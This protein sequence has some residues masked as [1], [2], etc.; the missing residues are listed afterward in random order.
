MKKVHCVVVL[1]VLLT[2]STVGLALAAE[3]APQRV[4]DLA[5]SKLVQL[6]KNPVIIAAVRAENAKGK[7]LAEIK[8]R[9]KKWAATPGV[10]S[11]M[12]SL[13]ENDCAKALFDI[14]KEYPYLVEIFVKD[15]QGAHVAMTD[16]TTWYYH[17]DK[18]KFIKAFNG[19]RGAL[20]LS[21][22]QFDES[23]QAYLVQV[24][25]PV[26]DGK[27]CIGVVIFGVD[28]DKFK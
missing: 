14:Q 18:D 5:T 28:V 6:A 3:K 15:N 25:V 10:D 2:A 9:Q 4:Q 24:S 7:S 11:F 22:V 13:M 17:G 8:E 27:S 26:M 20:Y 12:K 21:D 19:G 23:S 16:K 1:A